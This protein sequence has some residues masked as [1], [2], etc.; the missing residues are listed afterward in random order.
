MQTTGRRCIHKN[1]SISQMTQ[2]VWKALKVNIKPPS[3]TAD[4]WTL[5]MFKW[6]LAHYKFFTHPKSKLHIWHL[7]KSVS[8]WKFPSVFIFKRKHSELVLPDDIMLILIISPLKW[9]KKLLILSDL[10][11]KLLL[12]NCRKTFCLEV[13]PSPFQEV[14]AELGSDSKWQ[15][16]VCCP[17]PFPSSF[18]NLFGFSFPIFFWVAL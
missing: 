1:W 14:G 7:S 12:S 13:S 4:I 18:F 6:S 16:A 8:R 10:K 5:K 11:E 15:G 9:I 17:T 3:S 2:N